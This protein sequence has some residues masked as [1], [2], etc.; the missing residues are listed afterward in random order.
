MRPGLVIY[1]HIHL[2]PDSAESCASLLRMHG[3][4][5][6]SCGMDTIAIAGD[7]IN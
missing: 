6:V 4:I 7:N 1:E 5:S 3:Y 2:K